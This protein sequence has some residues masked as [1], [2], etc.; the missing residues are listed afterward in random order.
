MKSQSRIPDG[1]GAETAPALTLDEGSCPCRTP[2]VGKRIPEHPEEALGWL[3][4][5]LRSRC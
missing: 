5:S 1:Y 3:L 2:E 4:D